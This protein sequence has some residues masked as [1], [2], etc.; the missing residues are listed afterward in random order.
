MLISN[1]ELELKLKLELH[2]LENSFEFNLVWHQQ[3]R[4]RFTML[5]LHQ[6]FNCHFYIL[7]PQTINQERNNY[8]W[9]AYLVV[10]QTLL[11][12]HTTLTP[13]LQ[14]PDTQLHHISSIPTQ[15]S[16]Q[17]SCLLACQFSPPSPII[18][19]TITGKPILLLIYPKL[20]FIKTILIDPH[21][22]ISKIFNCSVSINQFRFT[23]RFSRKIFNSLICLTL[24]FVSYYNFFVSQQRL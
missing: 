10:Y 14:S 22:N 11:P 1:L 18:N 17:N 7:H 15:L 2:F 16:H 24:I 4:V 8:S 20:S 13:L 12:T 9:L 3:T 21:K 6:F 19:L 5:K 23:C